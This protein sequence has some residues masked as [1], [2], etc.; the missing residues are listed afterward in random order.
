MLDRSI[1]IIRKETRE[2]LRD[3]IYLGMAFVIPV[4]LMLLFGYGLSMD[5]KHLPI[6]FVDHERSAYSRDY[7]DSF[8]N[9]DYFDFIGVPDDP[10]QA[11]HLM[12]SGRAR[13]VIDIPPDFGRK[14]S[15]NK[16]TAVGVTVDGSFPTRAG[17]IIAYVTI[18]N[19]QTNERLLGNFASQLGR[20]GQLRAPVQVN[21]S[22]WYNPSLESINMIVPGMMV[23]ILMLFPAILGA[24]VVVREKESGT[25]FNLY[26]SPVYRWEIILGKAVPYITVAF[27]DYLIIFAMSIFL[28]Q[29]RFT[30]SF[31]VLSSAAL[32]YSIC[33]IGIG[34]L[35]SIIMRTQLSAMLITFLATVTP[36][37]NYSGFLSPVSSMDQLGQFIAH[38]IPATYFM[39]VVRGVYL[40]GLGLG[41]FWPN[42]LALT[43]YTLVVYSLA[44]SLLTKRI[45]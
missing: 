18:I 8:V 24:L 27:L 5:V 34:L 21:T 26:A 22:Y 36:A 39:E 7:I 42:L 14:L 28:F 37:F 31:W 12:R 25:I 6:A 9:S 1:A 35:F 19:A 43:I 15:S 33:T 32:L 20:S 17:V 10:E 29:V 30:G 16:P 41:F 40:K 45:R 13:V 4:V 2:L 44:W 11:N 23:L 38:L 3:P